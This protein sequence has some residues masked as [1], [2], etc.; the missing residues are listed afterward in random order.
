[1]FDDGRISAMPINYLRGSSWK[2][3]VVVA[4]EAQNFTYKELTT[5]ITRIGENCK[6]FICGDFMQSDINGK[7]GFA[8]MFDLF[9]CEDSMNHGI[10][11]FKFGKEDILRSEILK[12]IISKLDSAKT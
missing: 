8:P 6:L 2:D 3:K 12:F 10:H 4:D 9:N 1:M 11:A 5:L 7:S